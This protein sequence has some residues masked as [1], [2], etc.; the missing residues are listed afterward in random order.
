MAHVHGDFEIHLTAYG[1]AASELAA[2][3]EQHGVKFVHVVLDRGDQPSQPML[4]LHGSG[5]LREQRELAADWAAKLQAAGFAVLRRKIEAA[6]WNTGVPETDAQAR[7]TGHERYF[8]HHLKLLLPPGP[9]ID[10]LAEITAV[11]EPHQARLSRNARRQ[12]PDGA[13]ERF[14]TQR[15][16]HVGRTTARARLDALVAAL[17]AI[18]YT[19]IKVEQEYV[20]HDDKLDLDSGWFETRDRSRDEEEQARAIARYGAVNP[21]ESGYPATFQ[22]VTRAPGVRQPGVFEPAQKQYPNAYRAGEPA[23]RDRAEGDRWRAARRAAI[24]HVLTVVARSPWADRLVLR[25]SVTMPAFCGE[26]ARDPGDLDFV[27]RP[28]ALSIRSAEAVELFDAVVGGLR[29]HPGAG[30][31]PDRVAVSDIWTYERADG[32]RLVIPFAVD[33]LPPGTVQLD[34]VFNEH[35]PIEPVVLVLPGVDEPVLAAPADLALAWKLQWLATDMYP[36]G[37]DL[38][39]AVQLA[40]HT[41]VDLDLVRGLVREELGDAEADAFCAESV[42]LWDVDWLNFVA[43]YPDVR[44]DASE[45]LRRLAR[46]LDR[47]WSAAPAA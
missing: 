4:T 38:Y 27:V 28:F 24:H 36:Q 3:A 29:A 39:D 46:A 18:G 20:V 7:P 11:A 42:L 21:G 16:H 5:T 32:R 43:E 30:L 17:T 45:W 31:V 40:E 15:C 14:V 2:F 41:T 8:E 10:T 33:G 47:G 19:P 23:F 22:P 37:K 9:L 25:G 6:P 44:G 1:R 34:F 13:Q 26:A 35:L 12:R